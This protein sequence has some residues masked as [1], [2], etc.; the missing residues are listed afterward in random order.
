MEF[1]ACE[2]IQH[3]QWGG[4]KGIRVLMS[5]ALLKFQVI[6]KQNVMFIEEYE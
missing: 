4:E 6:G 2:N 5:D 3:T 1:S